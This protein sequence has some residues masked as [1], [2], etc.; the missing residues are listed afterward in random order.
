M[1]LINDSQLTAITFKLSLALFEGKK[2]DPKKVVTSPFLP[3]LYSRSQGETGVSADR[4]VVTPTSALNTFFRNDEQHHYQIQTFFISFKVD[5]TNFEVVPNSQM[6]LSIV[7]R[8]VDRRKRSHRL[9][10]TTMRWS[11]MAKGSKVFEILVTHFSFCGLG[12]SPPPPQ[13]QAHPLA[14]KEKRW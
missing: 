10:L 14:A 11:L 13:S 7:K 1:I 5:G 2:K 3:L 6:N 4:R 9:D 12:L 8:T